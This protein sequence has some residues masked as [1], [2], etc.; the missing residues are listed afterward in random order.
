MVQQIN[1][2][3]SRKQQLYSQLNELVNNNNGK[4]QD[5]ESLEQKQELVNG[6][7]EFHSN[8]SY[9]LEKVKKM[10]E[11]IQSLKEQVNKMHQKEGL[12]RA[13]L[14]NYRLS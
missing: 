6:K 1:T 5:M 7:L 4:L 13:K 3:Q 2:S 9:G 8:T 10:K 12:M 14:E 11:Q